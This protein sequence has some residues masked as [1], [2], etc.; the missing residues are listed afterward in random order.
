M[1]FRHLPQRFQGHLH[2]NR[3]FSPQIG[4]TLP[5]GVPGNWFDTDFKQRNLITINNSQV[6]TT[7]T[8]L[9]F[10]LSEPNNSDFSVMKPN[11]EDIR[12]VS[13]DGLT[14]FD[15]E[16]ES[17]D[18]GAGF[19]IA[20][21]KI[22]SISDGTEFYVYYNNPSAS[23]AGTS[24]GVWSNYQAV[25][26][27]NQ[28]VLGANSTKDSTGNTNDGTP[29]NFV[30]GD[31]GAAGQ[32]NG[33][34][35][36]PGVN[37]EID[38]VNNG[39]LNIT[40]DITVESWLKL[41][42]AAGGC[43]FQRSTVTTGYRFV[44]FDFRI[45][46]VIFTTPSGSISAGG[47]TQ[48]NDDT[49]HHALARRNSSGDIEI[50]LD[51]VKDNAV[52]PNRTEPIS[53]S[54]TLASIGGDHFGFFSGILDEVRVSNNALSNDFITTQFNNQSTPASFYTIAPAEIIT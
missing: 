40:N 41:P 14:V 24:T 12:F 17:A 15:V 35:D 44:M 20:W 21:T 34:I 7:Q 32:I 2:A 29:Q 13:Q 25:Y 49:L 43:M 10:L 22:P 9:P 1:V 38:V 39:S 36:F 45:F 4:G 18:N 16:I 6:P 5:P 3:N 31:L 37:A 33:A 27:L 28:S 54:A 30:I 26:H 52:T 23:S 48:I 11:G 53:D 47:A 50:F 19:I 46:L 51:G 8:D 42:I